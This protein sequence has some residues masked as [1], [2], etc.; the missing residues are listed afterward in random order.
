MQKP[1][2]V[3]GQHTHTQKWQARFGPLAKPWPTE[4]DP[5]LP[6]WHLITSIPSPSVQSF[7]SATTD[8]SPIS[9]HAVYLHTSIPVILNPDYHLGKKTQY[10]ILGNLLI[11]LKPAQGLLYLVFQKAIL[12]WLS[13]V[14]SQI[15]WSSKE[16]IC[17]SLVC[18]VTNQSAAMSWMPACYLI[19]K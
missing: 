8:Y 14:I 6:H 10:W 19:L 16:L 18:E 15:I 3:P 11:S 13:S 12:L 2:L 17:D 1:F 7:V 4:S 5:S 9:V